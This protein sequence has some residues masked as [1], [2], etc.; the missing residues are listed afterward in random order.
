[1]P[2]MSAGQAY[3]QLLQTVPNKKQIVF[4][5]WTT[6]QLYCWNKSVCLVENDSK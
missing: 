5:H 2:N 1:M 6:I 4:M 3:F